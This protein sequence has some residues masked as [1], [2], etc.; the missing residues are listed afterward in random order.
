MNTK[1]NFPFVTVKNNTLHD[2]VISGDPNWDD[3]KLLIDGEANNYF[4]LLKE[5]SV[6]LSV[7]WDFKPD[8]LMMGVDFEKSNYDGNNMGFLLLEIGQS[9]KTGLLGI[10]NSYEDE[11]KWANMV[12]ENQSPLSFTLIFENKNNQDI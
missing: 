2:I 10:T 3:Q 1:K 7:E 11:P 4:K 5:K 9:L 6:I 8:E 12:T